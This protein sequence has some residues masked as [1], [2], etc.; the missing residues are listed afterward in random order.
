M[1]IKQYMILL[2][3]EDKTEEVATIEKSEKEGMIDVIFKRSHIR[4]MYDEQNVKILQ[5]PKVLDAKGKQVYINDS[6]IHAPYCILDFQEKIRI[7][8]EDGSVIT[9]DPHLFLLYEE[10]GKEEKAKEILSYLYEISGYTSPNTEEAFLKKE[11]EQLDFIDPK[12]VLKQYL[13]AQPIQSYE[14]EHDDI[15]FPFYFNLSQKEAVEKALSNSISVIDGPPGTGKTQTILNLLSNLIMKNKSVAVVSGNNEAVKN[16]IEKLEKDKYGFLSALLGKKEN[17]VAFFQNMPVANVE[18]WNCEN[19]EANRVRLMELNKTLSELLEAERRKKKISQELEAWKLEQE[20]FKQYYESQNI[21]NEKNLPFE[22]A[23]K[24]KIISFL[25]ETSVRKQFEQPEN[26]AF[27]LK[28]FLKYKIFN[29]KRFQEDPDALL[30]LQRVIYEREIQELEEEVNRLEE[31]LQNANFEALQQEHKQCSERLF[32]QYLYEK[33]SKKEKKGYT[34]DN[35]KHQFEDFIDTYPVIL[36]TTHALR[37]SIPK[38]YL[39]DYVIIDE[40]SQVDLI[41]GSLALSCCKNVVIVGDIKQLP[42]IVDN[43]IKQ[44]LKKQLPY[45]EYNYFEKNILSSVIQIYKESLPRVI[46]REHYRCHPKIIE[47]CNQKYYDGE[48]IPYTNASPDDVPLLVYQTVKGNHLR[49]VTKGEQQGVYNQR[50]IDVTVEEILKN[51]YVEEF[52]KIGFVTPYRKQANQAGTALP[53]AIESDTVH[54]Y[55]GREKDMMIMSTVL[56]TSKEGTY[57]LNFVDNPQLVNVAVSRAVKQF[58]LVTDHDF[59]FE[60]GENINDLIRYMRYNTSYENLVESQIV[61]IFDLLYKQY[62]EKVLYLKR[63]M[64]PEAKQKSEE[65]LRVYLEELFSQPSYNRYCYQQEVLLRNLLADMSLLTKE[66]ETYVNHRA[67][68]D[69]VVYYKQDKECYFVIEVDGFEFHENN[70]AQK[71]KDQLKNCILKKYNIPLLRLPTN[72]SGEQEKIKQYL[73]KN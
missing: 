55:Q 31:R 45:S 63:K 17:Q 39:F 46:L 2:R 54:K 56:D 5:N 23:K 60:K 69:F 6:I 70:P 50:E 73:E 20:H 40:A 61:S 32:R 12:S 19:I 62:S 66:E 65:I 26:L 59:F 29:Y 4:Y 11:M 33:Y 64:N 15:V 37:R 18:G 42:Q 27:R 43:K 41:T 52:D 51:P 57:G 8:Q 7:I 36:S 53:S 24:E 47:F 48:L 44:K 14:I 38:N 10:K 49:R 30:K 34:Q 22:R 9:T 3:G 28:I 21:E 68:L 1:D 72:G 16:I 67:S 35:F 25:A 13:E 58:V 71:R